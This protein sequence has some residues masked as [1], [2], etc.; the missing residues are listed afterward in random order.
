MTPRLTNPVQIGSRPS[1]SPT[2]MESQYI[3]SLRES[4]GPQ[5]VRDA[6]P[7]GTSINGIYSKHRDPAPT[8]INVIGHKFCNEP[9][10]EVYSRCEIP[11]IMNLGLSFVHTS[12]ELGSYPHYH[13]QKVY[14]W[15]Q[16]DPAWQ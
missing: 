12:D 5:E 15:V 8:W 14:R 10:A 13:N 6:Q 1:V 9:S 16:L 2:R 3:G 7:L 11:N 4:I